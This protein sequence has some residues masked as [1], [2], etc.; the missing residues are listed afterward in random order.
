MAGYEPTARAIRVLNDAYRFSLGSSSLQAEQPPEITYS[1]RAHQK[2]IL[3][4]MEQRERKLSKG[5]D[6]S[7][8]RLF[9]RFSFL[10]DGVGVG[11]SLMVLGHIARLRRLPPISIIPTLDTSS[12]SQMY[13]L[14][15]TNFAQDLA[16]AGCLIVVPHTLYRQW[17]TYIK[18][19]TTLTCLGIQNKKVMAQEGLRQKLLDVDVILVSNTLYG[20][21]QH[22]ATS[23]RLFWRRVFLDEADTLYIPSTRPKYEARFT[24][25]IS[26]SWENLLFPNSSHYIAQNVLTN[27][28]QDQSNPLEPALVAY[29]RHVFEITTSM[30]YAYVRYFV[31]SAPFLREMV[32]TVNPFR[33][34]LVLRCREEFVKESIT[35]PP[36]HIRNLL[37]RPSI[38]QQVVYQAV[39]IEV[40]SL[41]HAG[42]ISGALQHLG[43]KT[44]EPVS[45]IQAVTANR[46]KELDRLQKTLQFKASLEYSTPQAKEAALK[47]LQERITS[48][49][50]QIQGLKER[51]EN[52]KEEICPIC[53]DELQNPTLTPC[54]S[55]MFCAGCILTSLTR[56]TSCPLCRATIHAGGLRTLA[57]QPL[58]STPTQEETNLPLKKTDQLL[59]LLKENRNGKF[60]VFS[61]Y[62]NPF[63]SL[64]QEIEA[65][66]IRVKQVA[67]NKDVIA[68]TLKSFQKGDTQVLLLNSIEAGAGMNITSA[69]H[70]VLLHAMNHEE[71]K[72]ILGRAYRLGRTEPLQVIRLLHP[73]ELHATHSQ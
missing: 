40:R 66:N 3:Y 26:A 55:R 11:K 16:E 15:E 32:Y 12:T 68:S 48:L 28:L 71:E 14:Q 35:L 56:Q 24:W 50:N 59:E 39:P 47:S 60:L 5:M 34:R 7:G 17:Q 20:D 58:P 2:A 38:L 44:E 57:T 61:R 51:I 31:S 33:G 22:Y 19:Q 72:Q 23:Q 69:T 54:C 9:S 42:D 25:L 13:S 49:E 53:F 8:V 52:Y 29:I 63:A 64:T 46:T 21:L 36:I 62:D 67:G 70:V 73:D 65:L 30:T 10:G 27:M 41:L 18:E 1:L 43:V 45:L 4:E 37:C 6:M